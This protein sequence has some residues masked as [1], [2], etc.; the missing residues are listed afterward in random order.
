MSKN[1]AR[2]STNVFII[3]NIN[4][5]ADSI[6]SKQH[7]APAAV[8]TPSTT[9]GDSSAPATT[10]SHNDRKRKRFHDD[11]LKFGRSAKKRDL[12]RNAWS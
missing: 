2:L 12:G 3:I 1:S 7:T 8:D 4:I 11:G 6:E 10:E 5:M 9:A